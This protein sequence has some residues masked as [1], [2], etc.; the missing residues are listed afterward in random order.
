MKRHEIEAHCRDGLSAE[1]REESAK[2]F[3]LF[4]GTGISTLEEINLQ[5]VFTARKVHTYEAKSF[6]LLLHAGKLKFITEGTR[7]GFN[8][9]KEVAY[10]IRRANFTTKDFPELMPDKNKT[11]L[12]TIEI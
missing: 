6:W 4:D 5:H 3:T 1:C 7:D 8:K 12:F 9:L 11:K 10:T 2:S